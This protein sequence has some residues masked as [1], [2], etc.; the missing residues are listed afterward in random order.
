MIN[1]EKLVVLVVIARLNKGG[2]ARF[3]E[4]LYTTVNSNEINIHIVSGNVQEGEIEDSCVSRIPVK[5]LKYL[6]RNISFVGDLRAYFELWS[7]IRNLKPDIVYSH[8]FKAGLLSRLIPDRIVRIHAYHG[9][10][11]KTPGIGKLKRFLWI[12]AESILARRTRYLV[13]TGKT[14][15][16]DL[17]DV[18]IGKA[19]QYISINPYVKEFELV[20]KKYALSSL[21]L[22]DDQRV[23]ILWMGRFV[24]VK[25]PETIIR[26]ANTFGNYLFLVAGEGEFKFNL[27][28]IRYDNVKFLGW[29]DP[30]LLLAIADIFISTSANEGLPNSLIEA[31]LAALPIV[32]TNV[33]SVAE[34]VIDGEN[35]Y[36]TKDIDEKFTKYLKILAENPSLRIRLGKVSRNLALKK[37]GPEQFAQ[38][39]MNIFRL[40]R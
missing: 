28:D 33:G 3:I 27:S 38:D 15:A 21:G 11:L 35:G 5:K 17:L 7:L 9:H 10:H 36:L 26:L 22:T 31:S 23:K 29:Q 20:D 30:N 16:N 19:S 12:T 13:T 32:A 18:K 25:R 14:V 4:N 1:S 6:G 34:I 8:T 24:P 37:F 39:Q 40:T 2:T